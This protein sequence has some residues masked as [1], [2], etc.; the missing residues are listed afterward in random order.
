MFVCLCNGYRDSDLRA[1]ANQGLHR[2]ED[3]YA[4]LGGAPACRQCVD[5][6]QEIL[7]QEIALAASGE[8]AAREPTAPKS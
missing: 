4:A 6:A 2:V 3:A 7:D 1:L 8:P 5:Y